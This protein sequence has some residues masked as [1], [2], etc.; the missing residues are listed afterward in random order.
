VHFATDGVYGVEVRRWPRELNA[1]IAGTPAST[2][3]ADAWLDGAPVGGTLYRS[4]PKALPVTKARL[5]IGDNVLEYE[6]APGDTAKI[7][8]VQVGAG[9][10]SI[11]A[12]WFDSEGKPICGAFYVSVRR[13]QEA[14]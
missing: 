7:F 10:A 11:E 2:N 3:Q 12:N 9:P 13:I 5:K 1:P 4:T 14:K 6:V 8:K